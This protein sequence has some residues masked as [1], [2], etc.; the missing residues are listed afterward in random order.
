MTRENLLD[1]VTE[2]EDMPALPEIVIKIDQKMRNPSC[3]IGSIAKL[4]ESE[5]VLSGKVLSLAR[6]AFYGD[7]R[8]EVKTLSAAIVRLGLRELRKMIYS[9]ELAKLFTDSKVINQRNFWR[10][11]FTVALFSQ[12]LS[13]RVKASLE[14]T[15]LSYLAGL[16][17]DIGIMVFGHLISEDY[18]AFL[19]EARDIETPLH[20]QEEERYGIAHSELGAA[21]I[22]RWWPIS[23]EIVIAVRRHHTPFIGNQQ[24]L[25]LCLLLHVA[26]S[27]CNNLGIVNG[28]DVFKDLFND[29]AWNKLELKLEDAEEMIEEVNQV[30]SQAESML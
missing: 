10:H 25:Q 15:E 19:Q 3:S 6:S 5:P 20:E 2:H 8:A 13:Q 24:N 30:V 27:I 11:S 7:S 23:E 4:V 9:V 29:G 18:I 16:M 22:E 17:H 12:A 26:H 14:M 28:V 1:L 21:F